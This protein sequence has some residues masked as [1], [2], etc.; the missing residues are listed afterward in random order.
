MQRS[1]LVPSNSL[2][3]DMFP[4]HRAC[5]KYPKL[6]KLQISQAY[7]FLLLN[8]RAKLYP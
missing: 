8:L 3:V 1:K 7:K 2:L 4:E 5:I 6:M